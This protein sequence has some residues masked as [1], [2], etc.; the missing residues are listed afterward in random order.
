MKGPVMTAREIAVALG[1]YF[2]SGSMGPIKRRRPSC[3]NPPDNQTMFPSVNVAPDEE[4][5]WNYSYENG[6]KRLLGYTV[7]KKV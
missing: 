3:A 6:Q 5:S 1:D 4:I 2:R 7:T